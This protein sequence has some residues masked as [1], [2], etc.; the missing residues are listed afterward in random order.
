[1]SREQVKTEI[2]EILQNLPDENLEGVLEYLKAAQKLS[3]QKLSLV[4][5]FQQILEDDKTL[6]SKLAQ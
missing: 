5:N 1:M 3:T 2:N 6:L 4:H